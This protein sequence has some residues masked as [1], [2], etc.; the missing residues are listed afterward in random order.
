MNIKE[1]QKANKV[2][3]KIKNKNKIHI[4]MHSGQVIR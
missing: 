3:A 2:N 4:D 1:Y